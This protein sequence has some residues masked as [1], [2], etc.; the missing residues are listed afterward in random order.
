[1]KKGYGRM[2][3]AAKRYGKDYFTGTYGFDG[4][5]KYDMHWWSIRMYASIADRWLRRIG[6]RRVL[7]VGCGH[8]FMLSRLEETYDTFGID[9]SEYAIQETRRFAPRSRCFVADL[10]KALPEEIK[11]KAFDLIVAK[12]VLEHLKGPLKAMKRLV[13]CLRPG[14]LLFFSVPNTES[15]GARLKGPDWYAYQ[16]PTHC[17]LLAPARWLQMVQ[18]AGLRLV[19]EFSDGYWDLPYLP[20]LPPW[21]QFPFFAWTSA[22][23]CLAGGEILPARFGENILV[24]A[25]KPRDQGE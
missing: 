2:P 15:L 4:L 8:G 9:V 18:D 22:L 1:M 17:A 21:M 3:A 25:E 14:G 13:S 19:K 5:K 24:M 12:Y 7:E 23:A 10:E 11:E 20:G 16:D 6:G